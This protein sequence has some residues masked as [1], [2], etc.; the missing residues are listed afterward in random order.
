MSTQE[1]IFD[2]G[3]AQP[4]SDVELMNNEGTVVASWSYNNSMAVNPVPAQY[5]IANV[6]RD[7]MQIGAPFVINVNTTSITIPGSFIDPESMYTVSVVVRNLQGDSE[8]IS[9]SISTPASALGKSHTVLK[10]EHIIIYL[11]KFLVQQLQCHIHWVSW[12]S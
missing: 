12:H 2:L 10:L 11:S 7:G 3:V 5:F 1:C 8:V 9:E 6:T 4:L